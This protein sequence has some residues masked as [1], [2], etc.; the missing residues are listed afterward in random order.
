MGATPA[1]TRE[2]I[3]SQVT[4]SRAFFKNL[5]QLYFADEHTDQIRRHFDL[6]KLR[7]SRVTSRDP[8]FKRTMRILFIERKSSKKRKRKRNTLVS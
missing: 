3:S 7:S 4:D 5:L 1:S 6:W 8:K 2:L